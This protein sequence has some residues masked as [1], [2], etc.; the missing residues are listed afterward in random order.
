ML[1]LIITDDDDCC[2]DRQCKQK[3]FSQSR[4]ILIHL[5]QRKDSFLKIIRVEIASS[6]FVILIL[7]IFLTHKH[8]HTKTF[9]IYMKTSANCKGLTVKN[10][11]VLSLENGVVKCNFE[12]DLNEIKIQKTRSR[13]SLNFSC[14]TYSIKN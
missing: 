4:K 13:F 14:S 10:S 6:D 1:H 11:F 7:L 12:I 2:S 3:F 8:T 5:L 9:H